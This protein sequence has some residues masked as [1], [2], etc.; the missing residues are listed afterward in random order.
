MA[1][2][3]TLTAGDTWS[4]TYTAED[5]PADTWTGTWYFVGAERVFEVAGTPSGT[6]HAGT[7]APSV[8]AGIEPGR[9]AYRFRV[10]DGST[11][12]TIGPGY[13]DVEADPAYVKA[14]D[15]RSH[16]R[17]VL[18]AIEA[19]LERRATHDQASYSIGNRSLSRMSIGELLTWRDKYKSMVQSE[20]AAA[21]MAAGLGNPRRLYVRFDRV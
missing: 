12:A 5:Y 3:S 11:V 13:L 7:L 6:D 9:Y 19:V 21:G 15:P 20:D 16:A 10:T 8:T 2:P 18:D 1:V 17:K 14:T 4:W